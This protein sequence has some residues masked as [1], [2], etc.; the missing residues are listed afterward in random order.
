MD[1]F[2]S[3]YTGNQVDNAVKAVLDVTSEGSK[4]LATTDDVTNSVNDAIASAI[5]TTLNTPV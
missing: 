1:T 5:T 3:S 4:T 2:K